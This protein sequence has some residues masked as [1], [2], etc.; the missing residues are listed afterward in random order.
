ME[1]K[2]PQ[3]DKEPEEKDVK[4]QTGS[5]EWK[6]CCFTIDR[7]VLS[8]SVAVMFSAIL[9]T[10]CISQ[11]IDKSTNDDR[12]SLYI[13]LLTGAVNIWMPTPFINGYNN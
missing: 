6:S 8:F 11:L 13:S 5:L 12:F 2:K 10:F 4:P 3:L 7:K 9:V 1:L